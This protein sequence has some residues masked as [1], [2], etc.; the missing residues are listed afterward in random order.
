MKIAHA[1]ELSII[2]SLST[3]LE[4]REEQHAEFR[5]IV[6]Y[7]TEHS[8]FV[9]WHPA[10]LQRLK[11]LIAEDPETFLLRA[12]RAMPDPVINEERMRNLVG[13]SRRYRK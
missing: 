4:E 11:E 13:N 2:K 9:D 10:D 5:G 7:A 8:E 12:V 1:R 6:L 3:T